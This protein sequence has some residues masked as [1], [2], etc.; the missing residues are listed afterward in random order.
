M[1]LED[2]C[3]SFHVKKSNKS[4]DCFTG[5]YIDFANMAF[6]PHPDNFVGL[7]KEAKDKLTS[8]TETR[9]NTRGSLFLPISV[10]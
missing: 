6:K 4:L 9:M 2:G 7:D 5:K 10:S 8:N 3:R 1:S